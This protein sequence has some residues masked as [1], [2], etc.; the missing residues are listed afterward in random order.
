MRVVIAKG[1]LGPISPMARNPV[2]ADDRTSNASAFAFP[3]NADKEDA[4]CA[5]WGGTGDALEEPISLAT[6]ESL[7]GANEI[8]AASTGTKAVKDGGAIAVAKG[9]KAHVMAVARI[10]CVGRCILLT[11]TKRPRSRS[12][13]R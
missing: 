7:S 4:G 12:A 6:L 9:T 2:F 3:A 5:T 8:G 11:R 10:A 1:G 13:T